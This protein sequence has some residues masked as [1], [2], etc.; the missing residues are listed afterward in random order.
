MRS[1]ICTRS[2]GVQLP[3]MPRPAERLARSLLLAALKRLRDGRLDIEVDGQ[4]LRFGACTGRCGLRA[5]IRVHD[6]TFWSALAYGGSTGAGSSYIAGAW[7]ADD[8]VRVIRILARNRQVLAGMD[9]IGARL[10]GL[11]RRAAHVLR[12]NSR[13]GART[14][15]Q[16][17]YDIGN[18]LFRRMLDDN[19]L[20]S[21]GIFPH[22]DASLDVAQEHKCRLA[23]ER[24]RLHPGQHLLE[25][26]TGWGGMALLAARDYGCRVTSATISQEQYELARERVRAAGLADRIEVVLSDYRDLQGVYDHIVTIEMI[27]AVGHQYYRTFFREAQRLLAPGG[28]MLMQAITIEDQRFDRARNHVDFIKHYVFPGSC[29]PSVTALCQAATADSDLRLHELH[30]QTAHY[31]RTLHLWRER[32]REQRQD[33]AGLGYDERFQRMWDFYLAYCEGGFAER[34]ISCGQLLWVRPDWRSRGHHL[35]GYAGD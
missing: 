28:A 19:M 14:N 29:I 13:A 9:G 16:A 3:G 24:L 8:L 25:I 5:S 11:A 32:C 22:P 6:A 18:E 33:L 30:D 17:H 1:D 26:G 4:L 15:I 21:S 34:S 12:R 10:I 7:E 35:L 31:A 23:C 20:Y 27:E 2:A